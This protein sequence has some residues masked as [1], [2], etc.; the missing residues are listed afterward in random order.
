MD[1]LAKFKEKCKLNDD[2]INKIDFLFEKLVNFGYVNSL[3]VNKL[4]KNLYTNVNAVF[5][6][7]DKVHDYKTGYYDAIKKE[8]YIKD[9]N[10]LESMFLRIIY[11]ITTSQK[12]ENVFNVGYSTTSLSKLNYKQE[13]KNF[14]FN[15]AV[16]SNL[17]CRLLYTEPTTLSIVPTYRTY[18]N[19]FLG[20]G[21]ITDNNIYFLEGQI[22]KQLCFSL[23]IQEEELY[24]HLFINP[25]KYL[26]R[27]LEKNRVE[28]P[29]LLLS[30]FDKASKSYSNYNKLLYFNKLLDDNYL[31][32]KRS[33]PN[34]KIDEKLVKEREN[35]TYT[36]SKMLDEINP[37][38]DNDELEDIS[39]SLNETIN[40][41]EEAIINDVITIQNILVDTLII[42]E[43]DYSP[44]LFT[45]KQKEL[46]KLLIFKNEKLEDSI[47]NTITYKVLNTFESTSSN[48]IEKMKYSIASEVLSSEKYTKIYNS[49][50]FIRLTNLDL[51]E[52]V[53]IM[54]L[55]VDDTFLQLIKVKDLNKPF[56][57]L[58]D[59]TEIIKIDNLKFL[60]N[61][62]LS[63]A[64]TQN[65]EKVYTYIKNNH[66]KYKTIEIEKLY[67]TNVCNNT[68][69]LVLTENDFEIFK[70]DIVNDDIV[71]SS[72]AL[73]E[74]YEIFNTSTVS[75]TKKSYKNQETE[76]SKLFKK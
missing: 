30:L 1:Y 21:I 28:N 47:Y 72:V 11:A 54:A 62:P 71:C 6:N 40:E 50:Q 5:L 63:V 24:Y 58:R 12:K 8:L 67:I 70:M 22:L 13:H 41:L 46:S 69:V 52:N 20:N 7:S 34:E 74:K 55:S 56:K 31:A 51:D 26:N 3:T 60:I 59:N 73:S 53:E 48:L 75:Y 42:S 27:M 14:G 38:L 44:I 36:I 25:S 33:L 35:L 23:N 39:V 65:I 29:D 10:D 32:S 15:R 61:S 16:V 18:T 76:T 45:I 19:D 9:T 43:N 4:A 49:M 64:S 2:F 66:E 68:L 37:E 17:V 57:E